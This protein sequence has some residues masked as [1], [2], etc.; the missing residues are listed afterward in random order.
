[1][2]A[3][4]PKILAS[5]PLL[6]LT[7]WASLSS[8]SMGQ[9]KMNFQDHILPLVES[10]C[11]QCHNPD[12][13]K[14]DLDLTTYAGVIK[15]GGSG[16]IVQ[17]GA[18]D[19]SKLLRVITHQEE[20]PMPPKKPKLPDKDIETVRRWIADGLLENAGGKAV[21][22]A[23][24]SVDLSLKVSSEGRPSGPA[25]MPSGLPKQPIVLTERPGPA[26][27]VASSPWAP[28]VALTGQKQI[29][30]YNSDTLERL[31]VLPFTNGQP[32]IVRFSR[33]GSVLLAG[34]GH[35]GKS[36]RVALWDVASGKPVTVLGGE[37]DS[38]LAADISPDQTRVALGGPSRLLKIHSTATGDAEQKIKKHTDWITAIAFSPNGQML[39]SADRNGGLHIWDPEN[40]Q[41]I[42]AL[43]GHAASVHG[44]AWRGDSKI[45]ASCSE[46]GS[47]KTW[48][49]ENGKQVKTW[50]AHEGG[51]MGVAYSHEG[52][53]ASC[54]RNG[55]VRTWD[56]DGNKKKS[57]EMGEELPLSV[58][59]NHDGKRL[60]ASTFSGKVLVWNS[61]DGKSVGEMEAHP[62]SGANSGRKLASTS[63][64]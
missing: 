9:G 3:F 4:L 47:I 41:E 10:H 55:K 35:A 7:L 12:K 51:A 36:G 15:G 17:S 64:K 2:R 20:P 24:P 53:I 8:V 6:C 46:D 27:S 60:I 48:E 13:K 19:A 54:G 33:S 40:G 5:Q 37:F 44:L 26:L 39:A 61:A 45:L 11:A 56:G 32:Q 18:A 14:A 21:A 30:L 52:L 1:M 25:A 34:G 58:T 57:M 28:V 59:F 49:M 50:V 38:V 29:F 63:G 43:A 42:F 23:K 62:L 31:G 16:S 22:A